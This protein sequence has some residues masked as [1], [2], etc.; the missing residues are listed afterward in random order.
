[1]K[2]LLTKLPTKKQI[3]KELCERSL[4][5]YFKKAWKVVEPSTELKWNWHI[6]CISEYLQA[7]KE[8]HIKR[9]LINI[10]PRMLKSMSCTIMFP[11]WCWIDSPYLKFINLSYS[12]TLSK[13]HNI[14]KRDI[15]TSPW[16]QE[17]WGN[18][19]SLKED[20][21]TQRRFENDKY[22][23]MFSTSIGG[24]LTG[25]G[26]DCFVA[27]TMISTEIG[28]IPIEQ[29]CRMNNP[30]RVLSF[31][32]E[33]GII[34]YKNIVAT[35]RKKSNGIIRIT[36][37]NGNIIWSTREHRYYVNK[38]GYRKGYIL[39]PKDELTVC[40]IKK[41]QNMHS[42]W[43]TKGWSR[44]FL[45][46]VL[47]QGKRYKDNHKMQSL[48]ERFFKKERR[49]YKSC[50]ARDRNFLLFSRMPKRVSKK[51]IKDNMSC[52]WGNSSKREDILFGQMQR[53]DKIKEKASFIK[54]KN[55][56]MSILWEGIYKKAYKP[57]ILFDGMQRRFTFR[58]YARGKQSELQRWKKLFKRFSRCKNFRINKR[59]LSMSDMWVKDE[60]AKCGVER[61]NN[62][63]NEFNCTS[64][65]QKCSKQFRWKSDNFM[66][67]M[68]Y[69]TSQI[70][71]N[72]DYVKS[73][74]EFSFKK[75]DV[76]DIQVEDNHNFFANNVLVHNCI[77]VDD[78]HNPKQAQ[79][80]TERENA[81]EFF[82][83]TLQT[84]L[85]DP[86]EGAI[87]V[88]MQR[89][90]E[91]DVS[92]HILAK[93]TGYTHLKLP[94][95]SEERKTIIFPISGKEITRE[96]GELLHPERYGE[97]EVRELKSS[98]GSYAYAGQMQ[99][100]PVPSGGGMFKKWWWEYWKPKDVE[101]PPV[102]VKDSKGNIIYK[103]AIDLPDD[104]EEYAQS[105]DMAFKNK[106]ENDF[107]AGGVWGKK[108]ADR[109]FIDLMMQRAEFTETLDMVRELTKAYP[110][111]KRKIVEDKANGPAI[112]SMLKSEISGLIE[113]NPGSDSKEARAAAITPM[114]ESGNVYIPHPLIKNWVDDF[115]TN[116]AKFPLSA[117]DDDIDQMSQ[118]LNYWECKQL[119]GWLK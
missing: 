37:S 10:P 106:K 103:D 19:F 83:T 80:D 31:N 44:G 89:L 12:D 100:E 27:G 73:I 49:I 54:E 25:E 115:I 101:L 43:K 85:N 13:T 51:S 11:T 2:Q 22:G 87:I 23:F 78:P 65:R 108:Q 52:L 116:A 105:W 24:T 63:K 41:K 4:S 62:K 18:N 74:K 117:N 5:E 75:V 55:K 70:E 32:H 14:K 76:Y 97:E 39:K 59:Q 114:V 82:R 64:Y 40:A 29:L 113:Y 91:M 88:V 66:S 47:Q 8:G 33:C 118:I 94:M 119:P 53:Q 81:V 20:Q 16:Y 35:R 46:K 60:N 84:R 96:K 38:Q 56:K 72:K 9:L 48:W 6:D 92:G 28:N 95:E 102:Q 57:K 68:S 93:E 110:K 67:R 42:L 111:A 7:V 107:V 61:T 1:M 98:M 112:I 58:K 15:I 26:A 36:T 99:Q 50:K 30:P 109:F 77:I 104:I 17:H 71:T 90:H 3:E 69:E 34:E 21:N 79:S 45:L 86:R